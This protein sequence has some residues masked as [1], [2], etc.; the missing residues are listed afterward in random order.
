MNDRRI[1]WSYMDHWRSNSASGPIDQWH[2]RLSMSRFL[3]QVAAVGFDAID[4]FDFRIWQIFEEYGS[5][6]NYQEFVQEHGLQRIVNIFH[7]VY[8]SD[9]Q[10]APEVPATRP[11]ILEDFRVTMDRWSGIQLDNI[12]VMPGSRDYNDGG[13]SEERIKYAAETWGEVGSCQ[14]G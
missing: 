6:A 11:A 12:I 13:V 2:S 3:K 7:G 1:K 14:A 4:T 5:I 9:E 8:Y 10:Y